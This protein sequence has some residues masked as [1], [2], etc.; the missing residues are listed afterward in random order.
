M[1]QAGCV[2]V[3]AGL[4]V[5]S[6][7]LLD[8]IKK[9]VTVAQVARV[10]K[11]FA[12]HGIYVH[13]Y[14]MYGFPTETVQETVDSLEMVRQLFAAGCLHSGYWHC[15]AATEHS[16]IGMSPAQFGIRLRPRD[17]R[18]RR[19]IRLRQ[20]RDGARAARPRTVAARPRIC[21]VSAF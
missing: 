5:A 10:A 1:A 3:T 11:A 13:A 4:E 16:P 19:R 17:R 20:E 2:M 6:D 12:D 7:R 18:S 8:L 14:L 15:L 9:G 21:G